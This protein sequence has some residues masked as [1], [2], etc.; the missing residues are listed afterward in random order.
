MD[1]GEEVDGETVVA[2]GDASEV[3]QAAEHALDGVPVSVEVGRE[4]VLPDPVRLGRDVRHRSLGLDGAADAVGVV[5][6]VSV[7]DPALRKAFE[8]HR[9]RCAISHMTARQQEGDRPAESIGQGVDLGRPP[10]A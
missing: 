9:S 6:L 2:G 10:A 1:S 3:L 7:Q 4:A 5:A 8:Q